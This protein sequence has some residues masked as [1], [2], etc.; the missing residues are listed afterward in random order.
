MAENDFRFDAV[1]GLKEGESQKQVKRDIKS[2]LSNIK[3]PLIG[4]LDSK[5]KAQIKKDLSSLNGTEI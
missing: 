4:T 1:A 2:F 5:T 3:L